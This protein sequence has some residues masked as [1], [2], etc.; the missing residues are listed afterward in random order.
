MEILLNLLKNDNEENGTICV[1]IIVD[2]HKNNKNILEKYVQ[3]FFDIVKEMYS[4]LKQTVNNAFGE[5]QQPVCILIIVNI[6]IMEI[7]IIVIIIIINIFNII[8]KFD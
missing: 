4:N 8:D 5:N 7:I 1:K 2:L 3:S 6:I